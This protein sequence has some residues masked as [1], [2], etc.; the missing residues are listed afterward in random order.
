[1]IQEPKTGGLP[2]SVDMVNVKFLMWF[3][4]VQVL[5][6]YMHVYRIGSLLGSGAM[7]TDN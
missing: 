4:C 1:M 3:I 2:N 5:W 7:K 6:Q